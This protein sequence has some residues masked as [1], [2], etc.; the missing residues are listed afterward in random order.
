M[1]LSETRRYS[2]MLCY[3]DVS[4][5]LLRPLWFA[6]KQPCGMQPLQLQRTCYSFYYKLLANKLDHFENKTSWK[7]KLLFTKLLPCSVKI[8]VFTYSIL[9]P[10]LKRSF[11]TLWKVCNWMELSVKSSLEQRKIDCETMHQSNNQITHTH[12]L[13]IAVEFN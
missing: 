13:W 3:R 9:F 5:F 11:Q 8:T 10:I 12:T 4:N 7:K 2:S 6:L 1:H